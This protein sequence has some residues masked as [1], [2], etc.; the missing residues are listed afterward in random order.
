MDKFEQLI[1]K[2]TT[3]ING[4]YPRPWMTNLR[5]PSRAEVFIVGYN[6]ATAYRSD[7]VDYE[8]FIDSL[9]NRN[10]EGCRKF[11][12]E[13]TKQTP[14]RDN[15]EMF[16]SKLK[17]VGV[18]SILETNVV[19]YGAKP[20]DLNLPEHNGGKKLGK[21]IFRTL[22]REIRPKVIILHGK[23]VREEFRRAFNLPSLPDTPDTKD[24]YV[25]IELDLDSQLGL[26]TQLFVIPSLALPAYQSWPYRPLRSFCHWAD[27]YLEEISERVRQVV[28]PGSD[29]IQKH[30]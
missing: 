7:C 22:V 4:Q 8:R 13:I 19:C 28:E 2:L 10:G 21:E 5:D 30:A 3:E 12:T 27:E 20:K 14:T 23:K 24:K 6:P 18:G 25:Q 16:A 29:T 26:R 17:K 9:F 11:Y 15:I 1:R